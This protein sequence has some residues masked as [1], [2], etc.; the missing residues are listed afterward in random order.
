[1]SELW[2]A[3]EAVTRANQRIRSAENL[4]DTRL[5][6]MRGVYAVTWVRTRNTAIRLLFSTTSRRLAPPQQQREL[7]F[8]AA[9]SA[10]RAVREFDAASRVDTGRTP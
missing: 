1:M 9:R 4:A 5:R 10:Q 6:K 7:V 3:W 2:P 8:A